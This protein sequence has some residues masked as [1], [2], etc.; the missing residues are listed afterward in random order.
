MRGMYSENVIRT[1]VSVYFASCLSVTLQ[2]AEIKQKERK[3]ILQ[4]IHL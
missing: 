4:Q 1:T 3:D 2:G